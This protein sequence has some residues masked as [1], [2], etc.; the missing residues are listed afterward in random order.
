MATSFV[1]F[2]EKEEPGN[3][4]PFDVLEKYLIKISTDR[5]EIWC[6]PYLVDVYIQR[7]GELAIKELHTIIQNY[8]FS[9][10]IVSST[11]QLD[12]MASGLC[13]LESLGEMTFRIAEV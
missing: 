9:N 2:W 5:D 8:Y 13:L 7:Y 12:W 6:F 10:G 1:E 3:K 11:H 4:E